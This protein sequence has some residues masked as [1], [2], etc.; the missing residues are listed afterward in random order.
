VIIIDTG[1][2]AEFPAA[3]VVLHRQSHRDLACVRWCIVCIVD[4]LQSDPSGSH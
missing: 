2:S 1:S 4:H 3:P